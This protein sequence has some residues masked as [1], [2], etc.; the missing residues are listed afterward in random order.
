[1][2]SDSNIILIIII[3]II[4]LFIFFDFNIKETFIEPDTVQYV[5]QNQYELIN[6][7]EP[8]YHRPNIDEIIEDVIT[9]N[10]SIDSNEVTNIE[11]PMLNKNF[12]N[13]QFHNDYRDV[14][15]GIN[16]IVPDKKQIFNIQNIPLVYSE[17]P[18][19]EVRKLV[20]DFINV[21]NINIAETVGDYRGPNSGWDEAIPDPTIPSG[22]DRQQ[23]ALGLPTSL[24]DPPAHKSHLKLI[25]I[26]FLQKYET[27][28]EIKYVVD[29][30]IKKLNVD[31]Q[32]ALKVSFVQDKRPLVDE[33]NFF[34]NAQI[35]MK[36]LI[37]EV[38]IIGYLSNEGL[39]ANLE[40]DNTKELYYDYDNM[41]YNNM[42]DPKYI[43]KVLMEKYR[44]KSIR[45]QSR[46]NML[47]EEGQDFHRTLPS[48]YDFSN[49]KAT[50]T[51]FDD[52]N[53][54]KIFY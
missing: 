5:S 13:I 23:K 29:F 28:D 18:V 24:Y 21:L 16:N 32:M 11:K 19:D 34:I 20:N 38:F 37:E 2:L 54:K 27:D 8:Q 42:T 43:Q 36:I 12:M 1:M 9:W 22:W 33:N 53:S 39:D 7:E 50:R 17:P 30:V 46:N 14:L 47:D 40:F 52:M 49:I 25:A 15:T 3:G 51:I 45:M 41:E 4:F 26:S 6:I 10:N 44:E 31:D 48:I 35:E